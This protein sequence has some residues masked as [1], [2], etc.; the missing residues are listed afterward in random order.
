MGDGLSQNFLAGFQTR[1]GPIFIKRELECVEIV[2][3][4]RKRE[5]LDV[6]GY[7]AEKGG[8]LGEE[9]HLRAWGLP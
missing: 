4:L 1:A 8:F 5:V 7:L 3:I 6:L 2:K 9:T